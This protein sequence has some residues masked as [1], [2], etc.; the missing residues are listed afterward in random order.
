MLLMITPAL[1][2]RC[3]I[4][5]P[6]LAMTRNLKHYL[7]NLYGTI[8]DVD[9]SSICNNPNRNVIQHVY[10]NSRHQSSESHT[11]LQLEVTFY[12]YRNRDGEVVP[13]R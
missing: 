7:A 3:R 8:P 2:I 9:F 5:A 1:C 13:V 6:V 4:L 10:S 12:E 11:P